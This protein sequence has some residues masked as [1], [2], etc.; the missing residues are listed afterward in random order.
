[1]NGYIISGLFF[2]IAIITAGI[3]FKKKISF[4]KP[5]GLIIPV[6]LLISIFFHMHTGIMYA[7]KEKVAKMNNIT[8]EINKILKTNDAERIDG[9]KDLKI[10]FKSKNKIYEVYFKDSKKDQI[11]VI[12]NDGKIIYENK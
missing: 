9:N 11:N 6:S 4:S 3:I 10:V 5:V 7:E 8:E 12:T 2:L 1:M